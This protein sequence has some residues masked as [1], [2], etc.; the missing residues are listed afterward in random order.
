M[1][2]LR[3]DQ[4]KFSCCLVLGPEEMV[5]L[6]KDGDGPS[7]QTRRFPRK[8]IGAREGAGNCARRALLEETG[9][10]VGA[11]KLIGNSG[12]KNYRAFL[13]AGKVDSFDDLKEPDDNISFI[14]VDELP[15]LEDLYP[16]HRRLLEEAGLLRR[17]A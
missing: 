11:L 5:P 10:T 3:M 6:V 7:S 13:F 15:Y 4:R 9:L 8:I 12:E 17:T 2:Y 16:P 1:K 14:P